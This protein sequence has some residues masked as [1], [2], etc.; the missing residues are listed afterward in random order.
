M[1]RAVPAQ[2]P[3]A[4]KKATEGLVVLAVILGT[5]G[6][7]ETLGLASLDVVRELGQMQYDESPMQGQA[8]L[9]NEER[10]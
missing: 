6:D 9:Q 10:L 2:P 8:R 3:V 5:V 4:P 7:D 1:A